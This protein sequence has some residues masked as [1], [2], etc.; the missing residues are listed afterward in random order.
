MEQMRKM[1]WASE[2]TGNPCVHTFPLGLGTPA[3][4]PTALQQV[5]T[6]LKETECVPQ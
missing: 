1:L 2:D 5:W 4:V 6:S 3:T